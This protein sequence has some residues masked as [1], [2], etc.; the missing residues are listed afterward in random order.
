PLEA[1]QVSFGH[2]I[3]GMA[4]FHLHLDDEAYRQ[5]QQAVASN[6]SNGF[7]WQWMA[8]IDALHGRHEEARTNLARFRKLIPNQTVGS[9]AKTETATSPA[10]H[11]ER[12]R[13]YVGLA[14]AGLEP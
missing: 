7:G 13:F 8:A 4:Q 6:P 10:F 14:K 2:F 12:K 3:L 9:L 11:Q 1:N 5:M